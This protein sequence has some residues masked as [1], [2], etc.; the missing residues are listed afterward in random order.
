MAELN[1]EEIVAALQGFTAATTSRWL[2][3]EGIEELAEVVGLEPLID[4]QMLDL[5][6]LLLRLGLETIGLPTGFDDPEPQRRGLT[7]VAPG[8]RRASEPQAGPKPRSWKLSDADRLLFATAYDVM[9][10]AGWDPYAKQA[11][12]AAPQAFADAPGLWRSVHAMAC[13]RV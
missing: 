2:P 6:A 10:L 7:I 12:P 8:T 3:Y 1:R 13:S 11:T 4:Q 9:V 5:G